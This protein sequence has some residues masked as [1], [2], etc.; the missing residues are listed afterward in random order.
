VDDG[1]ALLA[2]VGAPTVDASAP[3]RARVDVMRLG[4]LAEVIAFDT[5][6]FGA[7]R[8]AVLAAYLAD[9]VGR[10]FV[11]RGE[12]GEVRAFLFAQARMLGPWVAV[13][14]EDAEA[15]LAHALALPFAGGPLV[16]APEANGAALALLARYGFA[17]QRTLRHMRRGGG[18]LLERRMHLYGQASFA[19][20]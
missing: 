10:A 9:G 1:V 18:P 15:V 14:P 11:A 7:D 20:G 17:A 6:R 19:I 4:D 16:I 5:P 8:G 2:R 3:G 13:T 12:R